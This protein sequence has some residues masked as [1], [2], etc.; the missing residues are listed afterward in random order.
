MLLL[1]IFTMILNRHL[2]TLR[3]RPAITDDHMSPVLQIL[4]W[5]FLSFVILSVATQLVMKRAIMRHLGASDM[6]LFVALVLTVG[7]MSS[8]L[9][10][11][12]QNI[13]N[14]PSGL[15]TSE[16]DATFKALYSGDILGI[17]SLAAV[18]GS[19]LMALY[20]ITPRSEHRTVIATTGALVVTWLFASSF[21]LGFQCPWPQRWN[22]QNTMCSN[23]HLTRTVI[24]SFN[25]IT[26]VFLIAIPSLIVIPTK[27]SWDHRV[28]IL[29]GFWSR[30]GAIAA[31]A[32][33]L[34]YIR[35]LVLDDS[36][37]KNIWRATLAAEVVQ[38]SSVMTACIP[39]L[40]PFLISLES[41][42]LR[43]DDM[44]RRFEGSNDSSRATGGKISIKWTSSYIRIKNQRRT[45]GSAE[46]RTLSRNNMSTV[47]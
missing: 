32:V 4:T 23:I 24:V 17:S 14:I 36:V 8:I 41:G 1:R 39:F 9:S 19:V 30:I 15:T 46:L 45:G 47:V 44:N 29:L 42:F 28:T 40:K 21:A 18:K 5:L 10:P 12:G 3:E 33:H 13:G 16:V 38:V 22:I 25:I 31:S 35:V 20:A 27:M 26:D 2:S 37:L 34:Y 7:Q 6:V 11:P 43:A